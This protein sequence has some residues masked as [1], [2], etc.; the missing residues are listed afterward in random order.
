M[1]SVDFEVV[2]GD[3]PLV[4]GDRLDGSGGVVA[5]GEVVSDVQVAGEDPAFA[6]DVEGVFFGDD[7][8]GG[9]ADGDGLQGG[10]LLVEQADDL[11]QLVGARVE[12]AGPDLVADLD[13]FD[14]HWPVVGVDEG[15]GDEAV[16]SFAGDAF[17]GPADS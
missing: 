14:G 13:V 1:W 15:S 12:G 5:L 3:D 8:L 2:D 7:D 4:A 10:G 11:T 6:V 17:G 9:V 16:A